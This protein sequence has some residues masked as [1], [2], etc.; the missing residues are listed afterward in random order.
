MRGW[1][2]YFKHAVCTA[3]LSSLAS[4][5]W[6]RVS[7]WW[8]ALHRWKRKDVRRR[9]TGHS[10]RW[11]RPSADGTEL[12]DLQAV[13]ATRYRYRAN[14]IPGPWTASTTPE[15]QS[16]WRARY[17]ETGTP[18]SA[19]G[20]ENRTGGNTGTALRADSTD[21]P[22]LPCHAGRQTP[23]PAGG[24]RL[25]T[26]ARRPG[27]E[28]S[29][30]TYPPLPGRLAARNRSPGTQW[31]LRCRLDVS[32]PKRVG[33]RASQADPARYPARR[34]MICTTRATVVL[35]PDGRSSG[36]GREQELPVQGRSAETTG[37]ERVRNVAAGAEIRHVS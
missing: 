22:L 3:T 14:T 25:A 26:H 17:S 19:S 4:F 21:T 24:C 16:P 30:V 20:T 7:S 8:M 10:G 36:Y 28:I 9:L 5:T 6:H 32:R 12:F 11:Q 37:R 18:G 23:G 29:P 34:L 1:A 33:N 35:S 2:N 27:A 13:A 15:R 31:A